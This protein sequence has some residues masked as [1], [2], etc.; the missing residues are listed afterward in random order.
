MGLIKIRFLLLHISTQITSTWYC[1]LSQRRIFLY[2]DNKH[3]GFL[4]KN[5]G[6][7]SV[8]QLTLKTGIF[9]PITS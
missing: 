5:L 1:L 9:N 7:S 4:G 6:D 3:E 2:N 8:K